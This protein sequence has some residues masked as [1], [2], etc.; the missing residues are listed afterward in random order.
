MTSLS[1]ILAPIQKP[2][3]MELKYILRKRKDGWRKTLVF[4][5]PSFHLSTHVTLKLV[6]SR[7]L[8]PVNGFSLRTCKGEDFYPCCIS[9]AMRQKID[10]MTSLKCFEEFVADLGTEPN[11]SESLIYILHSSS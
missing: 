8:N 1:V 7:H 3:S 9:G 10:Q 11:S 2:S 4:M 6:I 5:W